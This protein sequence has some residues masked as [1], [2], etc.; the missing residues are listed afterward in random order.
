MR[1]T[2][3]DE[4]FHK[5]IDQ[6]K[7]IKEKKNDEENRVWWT[8]PQENWPAGVGNLTFISVEN[9][10]C[11]FRTKGREI[12]EYTTEEEAEEEKGR[13]ATAARGKLGMKLRLVR[14]GGEDR[15]TF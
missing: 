8:I 13:R 15:R 14:P 10:K 7:L 6:H 3:H 4:P 5:K 12:G 1:K 2:E 9:F 11:Y